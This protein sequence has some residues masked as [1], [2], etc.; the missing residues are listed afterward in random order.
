[1]YFPPK[2][3]Q[4]NRENRSHYLTIVLMFLIVAVAFWITEYRTKTCDWRYP[5]RPIVGPMTSG[6]FELEKCMEEARNQVAH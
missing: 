6:L 1:M 4:P 2:F 3:Y 5:I